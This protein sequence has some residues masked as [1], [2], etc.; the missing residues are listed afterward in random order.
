M[1]ADPNFQ[2]PWSDYDTMGSTLD[3]LTTVDNASNDCYV[4]FN[5]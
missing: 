2:F 4:P 5:N 1:V 3:D